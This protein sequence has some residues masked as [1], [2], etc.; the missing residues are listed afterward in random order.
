MRAHAKYTPTGE[1]LT[2]LPLHLS[3]AAARLNRYTEGMEILCFVWWFSPD[4][5][6]ASPYFCLTGLP[7][8]LCASLPVSMGVKREMGKHLKKTCTLKSASL[9]WCILNHMAQKRLKNT[10]EIFKALATLE[11]LP[12]TVVGLL[13][14]SHPP[15]SPPHLPR[16]P[17][18]FTFFPSC[19]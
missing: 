4:S 7:F 18:P 17:L 15:P 8:C 10:V 14:L 5:G 9:K 19:F 1:A 12:L 13:P 3:S 16:L 2:P 6:L 11:F